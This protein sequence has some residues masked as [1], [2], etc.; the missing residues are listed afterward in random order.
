MSLK[1]VR[2]L[3]GRIL[4]A[5]ESRVRILDAKRASEAL[6]RDDVRALIREGAIVAKQ[7]KGV[8]RAKARFKHFRVHSGRRRGRGSKKG[9]VRSCE[10]R[11]WISLVRALRRALAFQRGKISSRDYRR[12]YGMI[13]G[14]FFRNKKQ[15]AEFLREIKK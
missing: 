12:V 9:G 15:L 6:T 2:R 1:T 4:G 8:G 7:R 14:G 5:G 3:A 11:K 10:K 13:K